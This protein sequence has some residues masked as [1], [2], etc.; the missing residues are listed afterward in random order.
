MGLN[1]NMRL[2]MSGVLNICQLVGVATSIYTMDRFGRRKLLLWGS[3][4]TAAA[5]III[6]VL[7]SKYS[8]DWS[9]HSTEGW[10]SVAMLLF[11]M[12]GELYMPSQDRYPLISDGL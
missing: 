6:S 8:D 7:V 2:I 10:V 11:Y 1:Y 4:G 5:H 12:V 3:V 9:A